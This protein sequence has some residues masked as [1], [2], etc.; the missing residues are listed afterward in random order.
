MATWRG[1]AGLGVGRV[2]GN[3]AQSDSKQ[4]GCVTCGG[5]TVSGRAQ[6]RP[7]GRF[8]K[9]SPKQAHC[10]FAAPSTGW[11]A[12]PHLYIA[13]TKL[14]PNRAARSALFVLLTCLCC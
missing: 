6:R 9:A 8:S 14:K 3:V 4:T 1:V 11:D 12:S 2:R 5:L 7:V 13:T 10:S